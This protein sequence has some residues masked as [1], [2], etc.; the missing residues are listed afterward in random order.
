MATL[1]VPASPLQQDRP[2]ARALYR[3]PGGKDRVAV[4]LQRMV[5][6]G[7]QVTRENRHR[8]MEN[9]AMFRGDQWISVNVSTNAVRLMAS[10]NYLRSGRRRDTINRLRQFTEGRIANYATERPAFEVQPSGTDE[11]AVDGARQAERLVDAMWGEAGWNVKSKIPELARAGEIDGLSF[12][13]VGWDPNRGPKG[14]VPLAVT[15]EGPV[16]DP[17]MLGALQEMDPAGETLW[18]WVYPEEPLGDVSWRVVRANALAVDPYAV[19]DFT[20]ARWVIE[21]R[22]IDRDAAQRMAKRPLNEMIEESDTLLGRHGESS[23]LP[24]V[25]VDDGDPGTSR[26]RRDSV[27]IHELYRVPGG[28]WPN[29]AHIVWLDRAPATPLVET[30]WNDD[31][32]Y[33]AFT[34]KPDG[35]H[36][37]N[38]RG[39]VDD[40]KPIQRRYNRTLSLLHEWL[41]RVGRPPLFVY[42]GSVSGQ[43]I[44]NERGFTELNPGFQ[45][46]HYFQAPAEPTAV[47]T[48]HLQWMEQQMAEVAAQ[49]GVS[50]GQAPGSGVDSAAGLQLLIQQSEQQLA[51][52]TAE[53]VGVYEWA[54]SRALK[55]VHE[56]YILP[57]AINA[58]G[59]SD[60][61]EFLSFTGE[62]L[63]GAHRFKVV[64]SLQPATRAAELQGIMQFAPLIG[65]DI[66]PFVSRLI[67]GDTTDFKRAD[68][69]QRKRQQRKNRVM[70]MVATDEKARLVF[71]NFQQEQQAFSQAMQ[72][73]AMQA[74]MAAQMMPQVAMPGPDGVP[75]PPPAPPSPLDL[76]AARGI[77]PPSLLDGLQQAGVEVPS[78]EDYDD[79]MQQMSVLNLWRASEEFE[80]MPPVVQQLAREYG[81]R[82]LERMTSQLSAMGEQDPSA[83][84]PGQPPSQGA[85]GS[86]P[87]PKGQASQPKQPNQPPGSPPARMPQGG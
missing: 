32:P 14:T 49:P 37:F 50:R 63:A 17:A 44:Y 76:L 26:R 11:R 58:P 23:E 87:A 38:C 69:A 13:F 82:L 67:S 47:L 43:S 36:F 74:Q 57:R 68:E 48:Q 61:L 4:E 85:G 54:C 86:P 9:R 7:R 84:G 16:T 28:D 45:E 83:P 78:V 10:D 42:K 66:R 65:E 8:W 79:P 40:L 55:I 31:L 20:D 51:S 80:R 15:P 39:T 27:I 59:V 72:M 30:E 56:N 34:P 1:P 29:G 64:G 77:R 60:S 6:D 70:S 19:S 35:G 62:M 12:L 24:D 46:P 25:N 33:R 75:M 5:M 2:R 52:S 71:E 41:D 21:S 3:G 53:L 18:R 81:Q 22:V 73:A